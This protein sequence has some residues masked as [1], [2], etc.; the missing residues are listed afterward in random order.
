M[1]PEL[2]R[3]YVVARG[4]MRCVLAAYLHVDPQSV[5]LEALPSGKPVL[6]PEHDTSLRFNISHSGSRALLAVTHGVDV[7]ADIEEIRDVPDIE[8]LAKRHF[9]H[10][11]TAAIY[12]TPPSERQRA[13]LAAWTRKEACLKATGVGLSGP[14]DRFEVTVDA[15]EG[16]RIIRI[17][18]DAMAAAAWTLI[19]CPLPAGYVGCVAV[20]AND[21]RPRFHTW[22]VDVG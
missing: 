14:L 9:T 4:A 21:V 20:H 1:R 6:G 11:E 22:S 13:F 18:G 16:P 2:E 7:G 17:D 3:R 19:D 8:G 12:A 10:A 5:A 15:A